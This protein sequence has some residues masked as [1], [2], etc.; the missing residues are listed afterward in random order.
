MG[1]IIFLS[2]VVRIKCTWTVGTDKARLRAGAWR[3][4]P[5]LG[6]ESVFKGMP[7]TCRIN[8]EH[9]ARNSAFYPCSWHTHKMELVLS[10]QNRQSP[11]KEKKYIF[12]L[13]SFLW[14]DVGFTLP[15]I[16][17]GPAM[18]A[19]WKSE[20]KY[21]RPVVVYW[22]TR[23]LSKLESW[24]QVSQAVVWLREL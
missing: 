20:I 15:P 3:Q 9:D 23:L 21:C 16:T 10:F 2:I 12:L 17:L 24:Y 19:A 8:D 4:L 5:R 18:V 11:S 6:G 7:N 1:M 14:L 13:A 22:K